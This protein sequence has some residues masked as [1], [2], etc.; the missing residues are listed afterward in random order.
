MQD[1]SN[2][3]RLPT[4]FQ[5]APTDVTGILWRE[6]STNIFRCVRRL[7]SGVLA[8]LGYF[9][10]F[11]EWR[12][13]CVVLCHTQRVNFPSLLLRAFDPAHPDSTAHTSATAISSLIGLP[14]QEE[15][16]QTGQGVTTAAAEGQSERCQGCRGYC[17]PLSV[18]ILYSMSLYPKHTLH[19]LQLL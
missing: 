4:I 9:Q 2:S 16:C 6:N 5:W 7:L 17:I 15:M 1:V 18:N 13:L 11:V 10:W 8:A 14:R 19:S 12:S 3:Q